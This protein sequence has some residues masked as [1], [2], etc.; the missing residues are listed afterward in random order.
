MQYGSRV[1]HEFRLGEHRTVDEVLQAVADIRQRGGEETRTALAINMARCGAD[2]ARRVR[3]TCTNACPR[4]AVCSRS[5]G[6][7][8]G[9]RAGAHKVLVVITDG[10]SHDNA[11]LD[12]AVAR[13]KNDNITMYAIAVRPRATKKKTQTNCTTC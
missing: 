11:Q 6:F 12:D 13:C 2:L 8:R 3:V 1:A 4:V 7:K 9:G 10:E 5:Q